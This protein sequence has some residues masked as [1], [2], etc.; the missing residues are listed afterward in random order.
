[1]PLVGQLPPLVAAEE[2][3]RG[4]LPQ[5]GDMKLA[6]LAKS[7]PLSLLLVAA[8]GALAAV[9]GCGSARPQPAAARE[10]SPA[11][12]AAAA[13]APAPAAPAAPANEPA[14]PAT[15]AVPSNEPAA[16]VAAAELARQ[17]AL[18][19]RL[20]GGWVGSGSSPFGEMPFAALFEREADGAARAWADDGK[21]TKIDL[22]V[23]RGARGWLLTESASLPGVGTQTHTLAVSAPPTSSTSS[24]SDS[25]RLLFV[26][27]E[28]GYLEIEL[29]FSP[30]QLRL[31]ARVRG[32]SHVDFTM[33]R[34]PDEV[35]PKLRSRLHAPGTSVAAVP[36][37]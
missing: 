8:T 37:T 3:A 13:L 10:A 2:R 25:E 32:T 24:T 27:P 9:S 7:R 11:S 4:A 17:T 18:V 26:H 30:G 29:E 19:D 21:G 22:R 16:P 34:L 12:T 28:P 14:A 23:H 20:I 35:L 31:L 1:V 6:V 15:T 33:R 36:G 5:G